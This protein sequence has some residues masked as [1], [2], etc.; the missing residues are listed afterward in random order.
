[1]C[2]RDPKMARG[3][4]KKPPELFIFEESKGWLEPLWVAARATDPDPSKDL[5]FLA[6]LFWIQIKNLDGYITQKNC[7]SNKQIHFLFFKS[8]KI[9]LNRV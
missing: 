4:T 6:I 8:N 3:S 1:M 5:V 9:N 2:D 7:Q